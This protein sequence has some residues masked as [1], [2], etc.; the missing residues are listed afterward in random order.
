MARSRNRALFGRPDSGV[1][2][3]NAMRTTMK[4]LMRRVL[5][6]GFA[7]VV[8]TAVGCGG[9]TFK[10]KPNPRDAR[11]GSAALWLVLPRRGSATPDE[12][13]PRAAEVPGRG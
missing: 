8:M 13:V 12:A 2:V 6:T 1:I 11:V 9:T 5:A 10:H 3:G 7:A 4:T